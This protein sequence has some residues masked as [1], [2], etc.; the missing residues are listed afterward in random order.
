MNGLLCA[1]GVLCSLCVIPAHAA[2]KI[3]FESAGTMSIDGK[4]TFVISFTFPPPLDGKTPD[5]KDAW[6]ELRDAGGN[7]VRV[8]PPEKWDDAGE[9]HIRAYLDAAAAHRMYGWI[10]LRGIETIKAD[11]AVKEATL[12]RVVAHFKDH[13]GNGGYKGR[14]AIHELV[15]ITEEIRALISEE[16]SVQEITKAAAKVGYR[17]L[18]NSEPVAP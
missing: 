9:A 5:G 11:A 10:T 8:P 6:T 16:R 17:P 7:F 14:V 18:R 4:P 12:R 1:L 15:L 13:P 3:T 2:T